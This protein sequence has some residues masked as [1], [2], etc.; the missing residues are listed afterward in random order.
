MENILTAS[1]QCKKKHLLKVAIYN[2][3]LK[4]VLYFVIESAAS[5]LCSWKLFDQG[6]QFG[7]QVS[8]FEADHV[9]CSV[10]DAAY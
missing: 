1:L 5:T 2:R 4:I 9:C 10:G 8:R 6:M 7:P 3:K